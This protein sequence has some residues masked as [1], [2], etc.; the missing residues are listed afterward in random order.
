MY[1]KIQRNKYQPP[2]VN[3]DCKIVFVQKWEL[4][5]RKGLSNML[6]RVDGCFPSIQIQ[7][8]LGINGQKLYRFNQ[9]A[10]RGK[11]LSFEDE[12]FTDHMGLLKL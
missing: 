7:C 4:F 8:R 6:I 11:A 10:I 12:L 2:L 5:A 1:Q 9:E 3:S